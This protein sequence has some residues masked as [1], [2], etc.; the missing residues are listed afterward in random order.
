M[1]DD[2]KKIEALIKKKQKPLTM[3]D[4][5]KLA[6]DLKAVKYVECSAL[7]Q[8]RFVCLA[9]WHL[10]VLYIVHVLVQCTNHI[11]NCV[12]FKL[13]LKIILLQKGLKDVFD[14]AIVAAL[15]PTEDSTSRKLK[16]EV[17]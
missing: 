11:H 13:L 7:S 12:T 2:P 6:K 4:G 9:V 8:V 1:R 5:E 14:E 17:L 10:Y 16:C 15:Q 3:S